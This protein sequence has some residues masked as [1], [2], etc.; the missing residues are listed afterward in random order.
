[1]SDRKPRFDEQFCPSCRT[2]VN[3]QAPY[4]PDCGHP[5]NP[6]SYPDETGG[7]TRNVEI[8]YETIDEKRQRQKEK[9]KDIGGSVMEESDS[10]TPI[11]KSASLWVV[12]LFLL[13][14]GVG[15]LGSP[16]LS[17]VTGVPLAVIGL[18]FLPPVH[19]LVGRDADPLSFGSQRT[20]EENSVI[21]ATEP[22]VACAGKI[23][24]G[25]ERRRVEQFLVFGGAVSSK[26]QGRLVYCQSCARGETTHIRDNNTE[27]S[28][29]IQDGSNQGNSSPTSN[30]SE[31]TA[32]VSDADGSQTTVVDDS[33]IDDDHRNKK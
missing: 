4:C 31:Q 14:G 2:I 18:V 7:G 24:E 3:E 16:E 26:E 12:G 22:C 29:H 33:S 17:P 25:V 8:G 6:E 23:D 5:I 13:L 9:A 11:V 30:E 28:N 27:A 21:N 20:V 1:M 10:L 32:V 15:S 19:G